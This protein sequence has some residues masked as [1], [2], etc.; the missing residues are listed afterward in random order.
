[1]LN[2]EL[3]NSAI[4]A[5]VDHGKTTLASA[6]CPEALPAIH[7]DE[8]TLSMVFRIN[9]SPFSGQ[10]GTYDTI[11]ALIQLDKSWREL[12]EAG[13]KSELGVTQ[14]NLHR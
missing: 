8:A 6:E 1:M 3:R 13:K 9:D 2:K 12:Y 11:Y 10:D 7:M 14:P 5:H 4:L